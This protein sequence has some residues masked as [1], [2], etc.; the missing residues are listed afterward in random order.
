LSDAA[1]IEMPDGSPGAVSDA[2][3][4]LQRVAGGFE[5]AGGVV[6][7]ASSAVSSWEGHASV[8]F[9]GRA[10]SYGLVMVAVDQ[11]LTTAQAAVR[12][13][14][15]ALEDAR[16]KIRS[17][18]DQEENAVERLRAARR[19][20]DDA[21][22]RL[23]SAQQRMSAAT[24]NVGLGPGSEPFA[25]AEQAAAQRDADGAQKDI[26]AAQKAIDR[27]EDEI[28]ELRHDAKR[29]RTQLIQAEEDAAG[30][31]RAAAGRLPD[32]QLPGGAASPSA[33]AGTAFAGPLSSFARDPR[34]ASAM[35]KAAAHGDNEDDRA[36]Y[37]KAP[38]W[39]GEQISQVPGGVDQGVDGIGDMFAQGWRAGPING[40]LN[41][42]EQQVAKLQQ[43]AAAA[44]AI[45]NPIDTA[46]NA[47]N[48]E[49]F[50]DGRVGEG[51][52]SLI[53]GAVAGGAGGAAIRT[54]SAAS[55]VIPDGSPTRPG[56]MSAADAAARADN[57]AATIERM[58]DL[59]GTAGV[60]FGGE[61]GKVGAIMSREEIRLGMHAQ[62]MHMRLAA[63]REMRSRLADMLA[64]RAMAR[65]VR[66]FPEN[67][68][69]AR[70]RELSEM[71]DGP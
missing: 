26:E 1:L 45:T 30:A 67:D 5:R 61:L 69:A 13:Y 65:G 28:R 22:D 10:A 68:A 58:G 15:T 49:A 50:A 11:A 43:D 38:G 8:S 63:E 56:G 19:R 54:G 7:R 62:T 47:V 66:R 31:V 59:A 25:M 37:E 2:G 60:P 4:T 20:L 12:R 48:Y 46:K 24:F 21:K 40:V 70:L 16:G 71:P 17:L 35:A 57:R 34:W 36:W 44:E 29:E 32:V 18:K 23:A 52:G 6:A 53:P 55:R 64:A 27:E 41:P 51:L 9:D 33:Y 3:T 42:G 39:L 14:E